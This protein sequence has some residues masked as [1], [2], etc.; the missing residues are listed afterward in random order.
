VVIFYALRRI[1][2]YENIILNISNTVESIK[3]QLKT[4]DDKG[5]FESDDEVGF[6]F[7]EIK[8]LANEL[9]S[10]FETEVEGDEKEKKEK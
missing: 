8:Q 10:L 2:N 5:T 1:N 3:L 7:T 9:N 6:F 4:I